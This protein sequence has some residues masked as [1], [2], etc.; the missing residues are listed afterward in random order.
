[1]EILVKP[2]AVLFDID[3]TLIVGGN[4]HFPSL[5]YAF[6]KIT[7]LPLEWDRKGD[8]LFL[9]GSEISGWIDRQLFTSA[10][11]FYSYNVTPEEIDAI[12]IMAAAHMKKAWANGG[13]QGIAAPGAVALLEALSAAKI[14]YTLATGNVIPTAEAK[15]QKAGLAAFFNIDK[16]GGYGHNR[17]RNEVALK[18]ADSIL[19]N[20]TT[21]DLNV[22]LVG[23]TI[24]DM[25]AAKVNGFIPVG[26]TYGAAQEA[27]L[28]EQGARLVVSSLDELLQFLD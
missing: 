26:V 18:A 8:R 1:M 22:F 15:I 2:D 24:A 6:K 5:E 27:D 19:P 20:H 13:E 10:A 25:T 23:D 4:S 3:G 12:G 16:N 14:P 28:Y 21:S 11:A 17:D 7:N 9:N